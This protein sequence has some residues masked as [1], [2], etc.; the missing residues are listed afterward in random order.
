[1]ASHPET[2][3]AT[4]YIL[5]G[6]GILAF[7]LIVLA[8]RSLT[9]ERVGVRT[10]RVSYQD[11]I[12]SSP[13]NGKVEPLED[14]QKH[15]QVSGVV[16]DVYVGSGENIK[17]G[18][19]LLKLDDADARAR[20]ASAQSALQAAQLA[21]SD[22]A[23]G[24]SQDERNTYAANLSQAKLQ[25]QQD[26]SSLAA[27]QQLQQKGSAS[28]SE[29]DAAQHRLL[30]DDSNIRSIE[31]HSTQRYGDA[32]RAGAQAKI[33]DAQ[34]GVAAAESGVAS[35]NIRSPISGTVYYLPIAQYDYV[36]AGDELID[37]ANLNKLQ[38]TAYF[39]EP[40][41]GNLA[42]GQPVK[43]VWDAKPNMVWHGHISIVPTTII[44]YGTRNVGEAFITIDD[45]HGD[46]P[47]NAN[48]TVTVT[49]SQHLHVL[50]VPHEAVHTDGTQSYVFRVVDGKLVRTNV[51]V[52]IVN[53]VREEIV[54]GLAE[55]DIVATSATTNRDLTDGLE[56]TPVE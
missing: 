27:L 39:D 44:T 33:A 12:R 11:L 42:V 9:R 48:V 51:Q 19:L 3:R 56:V 5:W 32:D 53:M 22:I 34:A 36:N 50:S 29:V 31:Q 17:A 41:I 43:I 24:G 54:S 47:P 38:I 8:V 45:A 40:E 10:A 2:R 13:T 20:L 15:A 21:Q 6:S 25:R 23:H 35:S 26:A 28:A 16:E 14:F 55:G 30:L 18:Q 1:M 37:V 49:T 4:P 7:I 46:L 52:G